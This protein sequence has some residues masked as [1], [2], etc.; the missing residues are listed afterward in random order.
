MRRKAASSLISG[1]I[2]VA[3]APSRLSRGAP[4]FAPKSPTPCVAITAR[5]W[6]RS[7]S[8]HSR[9]HPTPAISHPCPQHLSFQPW[10]GWT[11]T[12]VLVPRRA[13]CAAAGVAMPPA[14]L[15]IPP[16]IEERPS[17]QFVMS[18]D[19]PVWK[20]LRQRRTDDIWA[21]SGDGIDQ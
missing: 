13:S 1:Q 11:A 16:Q 21:S 3:E 9:S 5:S 18:N 17:S 6:G 19:K 2:S 8:N 12:M 10:R 20:M 15:F 7:G 4:A 14:S